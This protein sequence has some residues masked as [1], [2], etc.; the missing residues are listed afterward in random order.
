M[1]NVIVYNDDGTVSETDSYDI[2]VAE[3]K[4][5]EGQR[6]ISYQ[7]GTEPGTDSEHPVFIAEDYSGL[8]GRF[9]RIRT[10]I[11]EYYWTES[12]FLGNDSEWK[13]VW[14]TPTEIYDHAHNNFIE[15]AYCFGYISA[16][17]YLLGFMIYAVQLIIRIKKKCSIFSNDV[18]D[19]LVLVSVLL[20]G[21]T[22]STSFGFYFIWWMFF[23]ALCRK[24]PK[25]EEK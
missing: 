20:L 5:R 2:F 15:I 8:I 23:Y 21:L 13:A 3:I 7:D 1:T 22:E 24:K 9:L 25:A 19:I 4:E 12:K 16:V 11:F 18:F 14:I 6:V 17:L 10:H